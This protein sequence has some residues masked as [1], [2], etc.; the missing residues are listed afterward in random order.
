MIF[1]KSD[2]C[3]KE[4]ENLPEYDMIEPF[5]SPWALGVVMA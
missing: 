3:R 5:K 4:G 1:I 2:A